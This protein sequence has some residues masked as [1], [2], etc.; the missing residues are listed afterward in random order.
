MAT[1]VRVKRKRHADP[2]VALLLASK[3]IKNDEH[4]KGKSG[5]ADVIKIEENVFRFA[6]TVASSGMDE[7]VKDKVKSVMKE[8]K[9]TN[10][11][12]HLQPIAGIKRTFDA[13]KLKPEHERYKL[14]RKEDE[15]A[16]K[17]TEN[18]AKVGRPV[19]CRARSCCDDKT[20]SCFSS[21][22]DVVEKEAVSPSK[23]DDII[24]NS[25]KMFREKLCLPEPY[26]AN[27]EYVYDLYYCEQTQRDWNVKDILYVQPCR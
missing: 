4:F 25:V 6:T 15:L 7:S 20:V 11:I 27:D 5:M 18:S 22:L 19:V 13:R 21:V 1:V 10:S 16:R 17:S 12:Y 26:A 2:P 24:C 23:P 9:K 3:K 8:H 14:V